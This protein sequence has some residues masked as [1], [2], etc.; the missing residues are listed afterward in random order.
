[1]KNMKIRILINRLFQQFAYVGSIK[2]QLNIAIYRN[3]LKIKK[4]LKICNV[5]E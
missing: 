5:W 1:M 3:F 2:N 4:L